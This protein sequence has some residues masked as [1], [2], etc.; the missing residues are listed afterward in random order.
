MAPVDVEAVRIAVD[1]DHHA[2]LAGLFEHAVEIQGVSL[3][4]QEL[5]SGEVT[6][7][8]D[9]RVVEG[10]QDAL[11]QLLLRHSES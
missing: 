1:L 8:C 11:G 4:L 10:A 3:A 9:E 7:E 6:Q 2:A 5:P